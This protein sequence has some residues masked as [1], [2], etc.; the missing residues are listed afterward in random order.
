MKK[1]NIMGH[2]MI[3]VR[4]MRYAIRKLRKMVDLSYKNFDKEKRG[5]VQ[6]A[7]N[8]VVRQIYLEELQEAKTPEEIE[9][10][11]EMPGDFVVYKSGE[12]KYD[13][14]Y[15]EAWDNGK[16]V[17][18]RKPY[19]CMYFTYESMAKGVAERLGD[20]WKVLDAS[21]EAHADQKR[22]LNI[23]LGTTEDE[24]SDEPEEEDEEE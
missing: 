21:P 14:E 8:D 20:G 18:T 1:Y 24:A 13:I 16:A 6:L 22:L 10:I 4:D 23:L 3:K 5:M 17:T 12:T 19:R 11:L 2:E 7:Y 9:A 15:F